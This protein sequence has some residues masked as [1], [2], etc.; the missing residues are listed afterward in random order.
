MPGSLVM[1]NLS[2]R[3]GGS[4]RPVSSFNLGGPL[5]RVASPPSK[6]TLTFF[7]GNAVSGG[8]GGGV[9]GGCNVGSSRQ[10][11]EASGDVISAAAGAG[12]APR[13]AVTAAVAGAG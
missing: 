11:G 13:D 3:D 6:V 5:L 9:G 1:V 2:H 8:E 7:F 10:R 12:A 4:G